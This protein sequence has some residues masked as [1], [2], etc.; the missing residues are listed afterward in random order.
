MNKT[1]RILNTMIFVLMAPLFIVAF[2]I[3]Y[4][5]ELFVRGIKS[6]WINDIF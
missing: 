1:A 4:V 3:G 2:L 6:G 5:A